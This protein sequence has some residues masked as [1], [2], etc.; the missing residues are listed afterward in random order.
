MK[1]LSYRKLILI[2]DLTGLENNPN[3]Y[4]KSYDHDLEDSNLRHLAPHP[5]A[6]LYTTYHCVP[7][8]HKYMQKL[9]IVSIVSIN[10]TLFAHEN[11]KGDSKIGF[12]IVISKCFFICF[13]LK[14]IIFIHLQVLRYKKINGNIRT[15]NFK[16]KR[17]IFYV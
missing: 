13:F 5:R 6:E 4:T 8:V 1:C 16:P 9:S 14:P 2:Q 3:L 11:G 12:F 15:K 7:C 10:S 17:E